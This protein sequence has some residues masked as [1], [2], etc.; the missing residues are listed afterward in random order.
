[1]R[2]NKIFNAFLII[3][4]ST[5][6]FLLPLTESVQAFLVDIQTDYFS[7]ATGVG[8]TTANVVFS[9]PLYD[10]DTTSIDMLSDLNTDT[11]GWNTY[12]STANRINLSGLTANAS[13]TITASYEFD[14]INNTAIVA[15]ANRLAWFWL[16]VCI[17]FAPTALAA[18]FTER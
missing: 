1:M 7:V 9:E 6:L 8:E 15:I 2:A 18:I 4:A 17:A 12:N 16:L 10:D 14:A 13:R 3:M 5:I 11:V